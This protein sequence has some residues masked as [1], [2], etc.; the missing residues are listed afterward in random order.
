[1]KKK[2]NNE[3]RLTFIDS[4]GKEHPCCVGMK[5][6]KKLKLTADNKLTIL[7]GLWILD[8]IVML[9]LLLIFNNG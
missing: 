3:N 1:M 8:K 9:I 2:E 6:K 4:N 5:M 7:L